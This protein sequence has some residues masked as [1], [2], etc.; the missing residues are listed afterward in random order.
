MTIPQGSWP[1]SGKTPAGLLALT[2]R[3]GGPGDTP[4]LGGLADYPD[5]IA[6][7]K[8]EDELSVGTFGSWWHADFSYLNEPPVYTIL[9]AVQLPQRGY[10]DT[11][12][13]D[14]ITACESLS[15]LMT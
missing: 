2:D 15:P 7:F 12:F 11:L 13:A 3:F 8:H 10:G 4:Y 9:Q 14:V 5:V 1:S 6:V